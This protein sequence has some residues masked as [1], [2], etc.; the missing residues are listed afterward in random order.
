MKH[1]RRSRPEWSIH[2]RLIAPDRVGP[3]IQLAYCWAHACRKLIEITSTEPAPIADKG[4][5]LI[6][7]LYA[8]EADKTLTLW[9]AQSSDRR[10]RKKTPNQLGLRADAWRK[11]RG[12]AS[13]LPRASRNHGERQPELGGRHAFLHRKRTAST[14]QRSRYAMIRQRRAGE[15]RHSVLRQTPFSIRIVTPH[16]CFEYPVSAGQI[17]AHRWPRYYGA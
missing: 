11:G 3:D 6:R 7:D 12:S 14:V 10:L 5:A 8:I 17:T 13:D 16:S 1:R 9:R 15:K 2:N 4:V